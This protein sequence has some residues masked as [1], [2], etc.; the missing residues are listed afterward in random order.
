MGTITVP[1]RLIGGSMWD[2]V[3]EILSQGLT[4]NKC[5]RNVSFYWFY[6]WVWSSSLCMGVAYL[7]YVVFCHLILNLWVENTRPPLGALWSQGVRWSNLKDWSRACILETACSTCWCQRGAA[8]HHQLG[9]SGQRCPELSLVGL[10]SP[11]RGLEPQESQL[12]NRAWNG[13]W[14]E[15][16]HRT[17]GEANE[18]ANDAR[19]LVEF[20]TCCAESLHPVSLL[21]LALVRHAIHS[22]VHQ[23]G[24]GPCLL[25]GFEPGKAEVVRVP[26]TTNSGPG[27]NSGSLCRTLE[28]VTS[29][30]SP[31]F[32]TACSN[33]LSRD[34]CYFQI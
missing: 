25:R 34:E 11:A 5:S 7:P 15:D 27:R 31:H 21:F 33:G 24:S 22:V 19:T 32:L 9:R 20:C 28:S 17:R 26:S 4:K 8:Y 16:S 23:H 29:I 30:F 3:C 10:R 1:H 18:M 12:R 13:S 6:S 2:Q 14:D